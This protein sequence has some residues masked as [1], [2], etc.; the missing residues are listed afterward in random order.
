MFCT[1]GL[2]ADDDSEALSQSGIKIFDNS[3]RTVGFHRG[4]HLEQFGL[5]VRRETFWNM[6]KHALSFRV[7]LEDNKVNR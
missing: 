4:I 3:S 5:T 2:P 7:Q 6:L 1:T